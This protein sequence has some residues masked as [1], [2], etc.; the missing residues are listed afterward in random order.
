MENN[1]LILLKNVDRSMQA[2]SEIIS[3]LDNNHEN[4]LAVLLQ[5]APENIRTEYL[6]Q[7]S[8]KFHL[9]HQE[10]AARE[11][12]GYLVMMTAVNE[13]MACLLQSHRIG[14]E[15]AAGNVLEIRTRQAPPQGT[16]FLV[17]VYIRPTAS[18]TEV[19]NLFTQLVNKCRGKMSRVIIAGDVNASSPLWDPNHDKIEESARVSHGYYQTKLQRGATIAEFV[20]RHQL[21]VVQQAIGHPKP[22]FRN[23]TNDKG[24]Y[25]DVII[26]GNKIERLLLS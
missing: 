14:N 19:T 15:K 10:F 18:Y 25:I 13:T 6:S 2:Y 26:I 1:R 12:P 24:S 4:Y 11:G 17:N 5:D 23:G 8:E 21:K 3:G 7:R 16:I 9:E 22:T 20:R